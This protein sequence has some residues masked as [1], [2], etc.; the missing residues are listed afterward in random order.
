MNN[1][2]AFDAM[3]SA[4]TQTSNEILAKMKDCEI[5][6]DEGWTKYK[7][8]HSELLGMRLLYKN[9]GDILFPEAAK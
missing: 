4:H 2:E 1:E 6:T 5:D 7:N 9:W 3:Q 8:F